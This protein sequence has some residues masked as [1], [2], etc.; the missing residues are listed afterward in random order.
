M[1]KRIGRK[2]MLESGK[3]LFEMCCFHI[4]AIGHCIFPMFVRGCKGMP[5]WFG[6]LFFTFARLTEGGGS[7]AILQCAYRNDKFQ[8]RGF[9]NSITSPLLCFHEQRSLSHFPL[10]SNQKESPEIYNP[11]ERLQNSL[12]F[13]VFRARA[14]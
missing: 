12:R 3:P 5:G 11:D 14:Q 2:S 9:P 4:W 6:A 10:S 13:S 7:K 8:N 1:R